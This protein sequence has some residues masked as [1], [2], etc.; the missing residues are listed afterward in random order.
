M[1]KDSAAL[2]LSKAMEP[3][4][5]DQIANP[6]EINAKEIKAIPTVVYRVDAPGS[7]KGWSI[8]SGVLSISRIS[9]SS[10]PLEHSCWAKS[11]SEGTSKSIV[12]NPIGSNNAGGERSTRLEN[13]SLCPFL[14]TIISTPVSYYT[15]PSP[16]DS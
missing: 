11:S 9:Q 4:F 8:C 16:R 7:I 15:S 3:D 2:V 13:T 14:L 6:M 12:V 1:K 10:A 5:I